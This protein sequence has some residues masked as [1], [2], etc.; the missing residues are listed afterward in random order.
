MHLHIRYLSIYLLMI[1]FL[2]THAQNNDK[3]IGVWI[4]EEKDGQ[5]EIYKLGNKYFGKIVDG[6]DLY[7]LDGKTLRKDTKNPDPKLKTRALLN[8][9]ILTDFVFTDG[10]WSDGKIYDPKSGKT[11]SSTMK[12]KGA[13]LELRGYVGVSLFGRT[14]VWE[15]AK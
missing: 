15:R 9:V 2:F 5:I 8:A 3:I 12:L 1:S 13:K 6:K 7:E 4:N 14:T 11:Y 10:E